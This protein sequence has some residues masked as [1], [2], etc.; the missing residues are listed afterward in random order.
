MTRLVNISGDLSF[1]PRKII[2]QLISYQSKNSLQNPRHGK[3]QIS[4][5]PQ[6][7]KVEYC[8]ASRSKPDKSYSYHHLETNNIIAHL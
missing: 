3:D 1:N 4:S 5:M 8:K 2:I 7:G 6:I